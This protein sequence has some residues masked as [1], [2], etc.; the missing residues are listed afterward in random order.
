MKVTTSRKSLLSLESVAMTDIVMNL[1]VFF[2]ISFSLLY[3][4]NPHKESKIDVKLPRGAARDEAKGPSP[5]V[6]SLTSGNE[7]FIGKALVTADHL[8]KELAARSGEF[9]ETGILVQSD[10]QASVDYLVRIL[11]AAKQCGIQKLGVAVENTAS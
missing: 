3:T 9:K 11:D 1:F 2:F 10:K 5:L 4:F 6:V 7:I 8:K